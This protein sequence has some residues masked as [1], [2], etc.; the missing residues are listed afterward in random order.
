MALENA[1]K[2]NN[3]P[4]RRLYIFILKGCFPYISAKLKNFYVL[5]KPDQAVPV[6]LKD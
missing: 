1:S 3:P 4:L 6:L 5:G 2:L